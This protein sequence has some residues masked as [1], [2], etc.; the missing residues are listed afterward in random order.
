MKNWKAEF[1]RALRNF[2]YERTPR[3]VL[4][5]AQN[6]MAGGVFSTQEEGGP[7][8]PHKNTVT[9][10]YLDQILSDWFNDG[11]PPTGFYIAPFLNNIAPTSA[12]KAA[13]FAA[14]Q[15]EY[16]GY[17]QNNRVQWVS[18]GP[19]AGQK[20]SNSNAPAEFTVG[21]QAAT[22]LGAGLLTT[23]PKGDMNGVLVAAALFG[24]GNALN[25]GSTLKI[26]YEL[27]LAPTA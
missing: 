18:N 3:G 26:K 23:Q 15:G 22:I 24:V 25:P 7:W 5:P 12:L 13:D 6:A 14:T 8:V 17:T 20:V 21:A 1:A 9:L 16:T 27:S 11:A 19:S 4:F 10:E 2:R